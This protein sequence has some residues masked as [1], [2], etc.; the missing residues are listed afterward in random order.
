MSLD[1]VG[2][3]LA[4]TARRTRRRTRPSA[5]VVASIALLGIVAVASVLAP[6]ITPYAPD[7]T[8]ILNSSA[9]PT[10]EHLLG[11]DGTGRDTLSRLLIGAQ[12]SL[13]APLAVAVIT[14]AVGA[15]LGLA[16][17]RIGGAF[18]MIVSR[19]MDIVFAF[20]TLLLALLAVAVFG[21]GLTAPICAL[22]LGYIPF[23][24]RIV[25]SAAIQE[26]AKPYVGSHAV[27][28]FSELAITVRHIFPNIA[29][30]LLAQATLT[31]G[32]AMLDIAALSY[33]GLGVQPPAADWGSMIAQSQSAV[34]QGN[35]WS[36][37]FPGM[38]VILTVLAVNVLGE[39]LSDRFSLASRSAR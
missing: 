19:A 36:I 24:G 34:L 14:T 27:M 9:G 1:T 20:P 29:P 31:F 7:A 15:L 22:A 10:S 21:P 16:A 33:L 6:V 2:L 8:D 17:A 11:T 38:A 35:L 4:G 12:L 37:L 13:L 32:Y 23:V 5:L 30:V 3:A 28:G 39:S 18:D 26:Q 25:R